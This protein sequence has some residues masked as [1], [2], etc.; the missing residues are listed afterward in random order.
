MDLTHMDLTHMDLTHMDLTQMVRRRVLRKGTRRRAAFLV[1]GNG[2]RRWAVR[3]GG[4][5][6]CDPRPELGFVPVGSGRG[7][8]QK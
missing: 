5:S 1:T 3:T 8:S 7:R 6:P 4:F 2:G